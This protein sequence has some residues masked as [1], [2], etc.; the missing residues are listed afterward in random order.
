MPA[1]IPAALLWDFDGTLV[2][3]EDSWFRAEQRI[4]GDWGF[5]GWTRE[6]ANALVGNHL[7]QSTRI[8]MDVAGVAGLDP[9][10]YAGVLA[11]YALDDIQERGAPFRPG[12]DALLYAARE[13]DTACA[14][15]SA[16]FS[17]VLEAV[18]ATMRPGLFDVVVGGDHVEHGKPHPEPYLLAASRLGVRAEDCVAFEDSVPG[19]TSAE[20][21][22]CVVI[23]VPFLQA[24]EPSPGKVVWPTLAGVTLSDVTDVWQRLRRA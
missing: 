4:L 21:A 17:H 18:L 13:A 24:L 6:D 12:A 2:E 22:G 1:D 14:L 19:S 11:A 20:A 16:T 5:R 9:E 23:G 15:V 7:A 8:L 3:S 10:H